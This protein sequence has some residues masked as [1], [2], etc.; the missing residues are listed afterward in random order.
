M[1]PPVKLG[2]PGN[3]WVEKTEG[4]SLLLVSPGLQGDRFGLWIGRE[5]IV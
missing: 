4:D 3:T 5:K 1:K 2:R